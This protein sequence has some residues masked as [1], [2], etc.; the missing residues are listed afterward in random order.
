MRL[1][2]RTSAAVAAFLLVYCGIESAFAGI[3]TTHG[4]ATTASIRRAESGEEHCND[5]D[6]GSS[7]AGSS[8]AAGSNGTSAMAQAGASFNSLGSRAS[9]VAGQDDSDDYAADS[10]ADMSDTISLVALNGDTIIGGTLWATARISG[11]ITANNGAVASAGGSFSV[12]I[13]DHGD[14]VSVGFDGDGS[15]SQNMTVAVDVQDLLFFEN[16]IP[17]SLSLNTYAANSP[18]ASTG[19]ANFG[20]TLQITALYY[21]DANGVRDPNV[22]IV[23]ASGG[24]YPVPEPGALFMVATVLT[25]CRPVRRRHGG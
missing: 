9:A 14:F 18:Q 10:S 11:N 4:Y 2:T 1:A 25:A 22:Q 15:Y 23:A 19:S 3:V 8:C 20:A 5:P 13:I 21:G 17:I 12:G 16:Q 24:T 6:S 7:S